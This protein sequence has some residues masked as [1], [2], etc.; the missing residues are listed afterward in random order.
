MLA[1]VWGEVMYAGWQRNINSFQWREWSNPHLFKQLLLQHS[2]SY[3]FHSNCKWLYRLWSINLVFTCF[4]YL[5]LF[6]NYYSFNFPAFTC[7]SWEFIMGVYGGILNC[8]EW[9]TWLQAAGAQNLGMKMW[10]TTPHRSHNF[11]QILPKISYLSR[12]FCCLSNGV[13]LKAVRLIL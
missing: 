11:G 5:V 1:A 10:E 2:F 4:C 6:L 8:Q 12:K 7:S 13:G 9:V 3:G